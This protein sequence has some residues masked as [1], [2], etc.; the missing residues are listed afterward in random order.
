MRLEAQRATLVNRTKFKLDNIL[1]NGLPTAMGAGEKKDIALYKAINA[2]KSAPME[3]STD[4]FVTMSFLGI[5]GSDAWPS[6]PLDVDPS[7]F[8]GKQIRIVSDNLEQHNI[9]GETGTTKIEGGREA[10]TNMMNKLKGK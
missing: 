5:E 3:I 9:T 8:K 1:I 2:C 10:V 6:D 7:A 4:G